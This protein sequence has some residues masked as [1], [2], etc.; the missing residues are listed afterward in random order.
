MSAYCEDYLKP[1]VFNMR[2]LGLLRTGKIKNNCEGN[3]VNY[4]G[5]IDSREV[6]EV[7]T[8]IG[9]LFSES[10]ILEGMMYNGRMN[11]VSTCTY[12]TGKKIVGERINGILHGKCTLYQSDGRIFNQLWK[13]DKKIRSRE[14]TRKPELAFYRDG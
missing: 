13:E 11:G 1:I 5:E 3:P 4:E 12:P 6:K 7:A 14:I 10:A 8:G 9:R 2:R